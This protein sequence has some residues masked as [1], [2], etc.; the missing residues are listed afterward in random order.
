MNLTV[1]RT[2]NVTLPSKY[3]KSNG[4]SFSRV[5]PNQLSIPRTARAVD[6]SNLSAVCIIGLGLAGPPSSLVRWFG[7]GC[8]RVLD[9][10]ETFR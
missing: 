5:A 2:N 1:T 9:P 6:D 8:G 3:H 7:R 10:G 4:S